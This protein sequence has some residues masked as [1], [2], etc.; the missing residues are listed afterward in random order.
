MIKQAQR[1]NV[2]SPRSHSWYIVELESEPR[3]P[4]AKACA[5]NYDY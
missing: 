4:D 5:L 1:G 2:T 3:Q